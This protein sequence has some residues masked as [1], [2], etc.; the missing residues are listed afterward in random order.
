MSIFSL[1]IFHLLYHIFM[2]FHW[3]SRKVVDVITNQLCTY[4]M[5]V[6]LAKKLPAQL[7]VKIQADIMKNHI[8]SKKNL[9]SK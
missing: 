7:P 4:T 6:E 3:R 2:C 8:V 9:F 1:S 5:N